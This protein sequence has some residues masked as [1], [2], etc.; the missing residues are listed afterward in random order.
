MPHVRS[1]ILNTTNSERMVDFWRALLGV[2][3]LKIDSNLGI[4]WLQPDTDHGVTIGIQLVEHRETNHPEIHLDVAV[5]DREAAKSLVLQH[6][7]N[8]VSVHES[9]GVNWYI[10]ADPENNHFCIYEE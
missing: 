2:G 3:I 5:E 7:G 10:M 4:T 6:G 1:V 9:L 8:V